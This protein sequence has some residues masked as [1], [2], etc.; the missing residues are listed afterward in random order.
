MLSLHFN[1][2]ETLRWTNLLS[3]LTLLS[4]NLLKHSYVCVLGITTILY[5][6]FNICCDCIKVFPSFTQNLRL[7]LCFNNMIFISYDAYTKRQMK[8]TTEQNR[9][10][11][12]G[13]SATLL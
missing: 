6:P 11:T 4:L 5:A 13:I 12:V 1:G 2:L 10:Q 9:L 7:I 3:S 8:A